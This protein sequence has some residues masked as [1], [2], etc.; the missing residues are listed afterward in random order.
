MPGIWRPY[1]FIVYESVAGSATEVAS[2]SIGMTEE[3]QGEKLIVNATGA[4]DL[5]GVTDQGGTPYTN[6]TS[7]KMIDSALIDNVSTNVIGPIEFPIYLGPGSTLN[8]TVTDTSTSTNEVW[9]LFVGKIRS[10]V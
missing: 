9:F 10:V 1:F 4:F 5:I 3:F 2:S 7:A 6:A 8:L